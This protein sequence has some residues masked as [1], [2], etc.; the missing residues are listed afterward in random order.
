MTN[1]PCGKPQ[2]Y[3]KCLRSG[4]ACPFQ[5][6]IS[7]PSAP[8]R[9]LPCRPERVDCCPRNCFGTRSDCGALIASCYCPGTGHSMVVGGDLVVENVDQREAL[10]EPALI[11]AELEKRLEFLDGETIAIE[12]WG[13]SG[14]DCPFFDVRSHPRL[15]RAIERISGSG[16]CTR[17]NPPILPAVPP[18]RDLVAAGF[19]PLFM[20]IR[21]IRSHKRSTG[22]RGR[23]HDRCSLPSRLGLRRPTHFAQVHH[24]S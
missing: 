21:S 20:M 12:I 8:T 7:R 9:S 5:T 6:G 22:Y 15:W 4:R 23:G 16:R 17:R 24:C 18:R 13:V 19:P 1:D 14:R 3:S 2:S 11:V 10:P